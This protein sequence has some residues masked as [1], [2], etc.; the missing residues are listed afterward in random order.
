MRMGSTKQGRIGRPT[1]RRML[2]LGVAFLL[3]VAVIVGVVVEAP[4]ATFAS[5][6]ASAWYGAQYSNVLSAVN[7][8]QW[9][10]Q[11]SN[12]C[13]I[14]TVAAII[15]FQHPQSADTQAKVSAFLDT[16]AAVS[17]WGEPPH[18]SGYYGP[19]YT[20]DISGDF[21]TD[22]RALAEGIASQTTQ[23]YH[24]YI[25]EINSS[26]ATLRL[27]RDVVRSQQPISVFVDHGQHSVLVSEVLA[28]ANPITNLSNV[29]ELQVWDPGYG[30][31]G[32]QIQNAQ[33]VDVSLNTWLTNSNY[34]GLPYQGNVNGG[35]PYDPNPAIGPY[36]N[37]PSA[38]ENLSLWINHY[39]YI[40]PDAAGAPSATV[41]ADWAFDQ[42][43]AL[44]KGQQGQIPTGYTGPTSLTP[45]QTNYTGQTSI[46]SPGFWSDSGSQAPSPSAPHAAIA[47]VGTDSSHSLNV[48][49]SAD[50]LNYTSKL[51]L[52]ETS[53]SHPA[54]LVTFVSGK[55]I[56]TLAWTGTNSGR[57]L[58]ITYD[59]YGVLGKSQKLI[60]STKSTNYSPTLT[61]FANQMWL[62]WVAQDA[63]HTLHVMSLGANGLTPGPDTALTAMPGS[64]AT[65]T[66]ISDLKDNTLWLISQQVGSNAV[67]V[68]TSADGVTW[69]TAPSPSASWTTSVTPG[70][71][72]IATPATGMAPYY[73]I[74]TDST[75]S[76]HNLFLMQT[77][78]ATAW[79]GLPTVLSGS[80]LDG[81]AIGYVGVPHQ[82]L[83]TW[84]D[85]SS[86]RLYV[87]TL[88]V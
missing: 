9:P 41:N 2:V 24:Q 33:K 67:G 17:E 66:L 70:G 29:V 50:G 87:E 54:V 25:D 37:N 31:P 1:Q 13:G 4:R 61:E 62:G 60:I 3:V 52:H 78:T 14:A 45:I 51:T 64:S 76:S 88:L 80:G 42:N 20:A 74:W 68:L 47:W 10:Q 86:R 46:D 26:D 12:W 27:V 38:G 84:T 15:K 56:T 19:G 73:L 75:S 18:S 23:S 69:Q 7:A 36:A 28:T 44:I 32:T 79:A 63:H 82:T 71:V 49:L 55:A 21:G 83:I 8:A 16:S 11:E 43:D 57:W 72:A 77:T 40:R 5:T 35:R 58:N 22:P 34:W 6:Q 30:F 53:Y 48:M 59:V 85:P 39:V 81:A 65:P